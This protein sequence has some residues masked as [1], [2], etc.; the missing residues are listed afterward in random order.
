MSAIIKLNESVYRHGLLWT[1]IAHRVSENEKIPYEDATELTARLV[2]KASCPVP[3][4][5]ALIELI[6]EKQK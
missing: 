6:V 4:A 1:D 2:I 3:V 5:L